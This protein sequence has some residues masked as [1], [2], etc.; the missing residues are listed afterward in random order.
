MNI[1]ER[2]ASA[3][4][5][6]NEGSPVS[7]RRMSGK[8]IVWRTRDKAR[9]L[10]GSLKHV[11]V[12]TTIRASSKVAIAPNPCTWLPGSSSSSQIGL[13][14]TLPTYYCTY[15]TC[16][17]FVVCMPRAFIQYDDGRYHVESTPSQ[18]GPA[19]RL[20]QPG[21]LQA[22]AFLTPRSCVNTA[23]FWALE[24][25]RKDGM[26]GLSQCLGSGKA[27]GETTLTQK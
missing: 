12:L 7:E 17:P 5:R 13:G 14:L 1:R 9:V 18:T 26:A 22:L 20:N 21:P 10:T 2:K 23:C 3:N 16:P 25:P 8:G 27:A 19:F 24:C 15:I 4:L 6:E 11:D